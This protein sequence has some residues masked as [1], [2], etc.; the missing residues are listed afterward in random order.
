MITKEE[1]SLVH[2]QS[3]IQTMHSSSCT[4]AKAAEVY[5]L[6]LCPMFITKRKLIEPIKWQ[7]S[8][9]ILGISATL[10]LMLILL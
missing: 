5:P 9:N 2:P 4:V 10:R 3:F 6:V 7:T 1:L 8:G